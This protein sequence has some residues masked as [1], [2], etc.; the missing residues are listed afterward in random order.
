MTKIVFGAFAHVD[1]G[2]TSLAESLLFKCGNRKQKGR[3][4]H[5]DAF[6]DF[7]NEERKRG[8]TIF[9]K[10]ARLNYKDKE[11]IFVDTP[12]HNELR[13]EAL[14]TLKILDA[15][16]LL[17]NANDNNY[18]SSK[19]FL[20][21]LLKRNI[22]IIIFINKMDISYFDEDAILQR[23]QNQLDKRCCSL[24]S[25]YEN[26]ALE[27]EETMSRYLNEGYIDTEAVQK[28]FLSH[29]YLPVIF[30]SALKD[31]NTLLL[32]DIIA[33]YVKP[34]ETAN[35][36]NLYIYKIVKERNEKLA[37]ARILSGT[38]ANKYTFKDNCQVNEIL[39]YDGANYQ[40][41]KEAKQGDIV[42][43]KGL[44]DVKIGTY[45]PANIIDQAG[46]I[47]K[48][49]YRIKADIDAYHLFLT[50]RE[51]NDEMP[52]LNITLNNNS[53]EMYLSG[54]LQQEII[55]SLIKERYNLTISFHKPQIIYKET[56]A[57]EVLGVGHF[58][59]LRHYAEVIVRLSPNNKME[60]CSKLDNSYISNMLNYLTMYPP[61]GILTDSA[62]SNVR[63]EI[64]DLR[65]HLKHTE[66]QDVI[67]AL[68]RAIR[69]ALLKAENVLL[70]PYF[71]V[72]I[73]SQDN[74][75]I[76][77]LNRQQLNFDIEDNQ[78]ITYL[79]VSD[80]NE[81]IQ[82]LSITL[83]DKFVYQ[84]LD[85]QYRPSANQQRVVDTIGYNPL[86]DSEK[87][88][89]SIFCSNGA[90]HYVEPSMVEEYMHLDLSRFLKQ[91]SSANA[92]NPTKIS[93]AELQRVMNMTHRPKERYIP[94][95]DY[96]KPA[97]DVTREIIIENKPLIYLI[98]G[99]NLLH[100]Q[101]QL[102]EIAK[103]DLF[104]ARNKTIEMVADFAGYVNATCILVFDAYLRSNQKATVIEHD[105]I[106]IVYTKE[107]QTADT[108]IELKAK[109]LQDR[110]KVNVVTSDGL[111]QLRVIS[112]GSTRISSREFIQRY[113][114]FQKNLKKQNSLNFN[115][116]LLDLRKLLEED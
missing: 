50:I 70:E 89:G 79:P 42:A 32:L 63:I 97:E 109:E 49:A 16:V 14:R 13:N 54:K 57:N 15:A 4:D 106:T 92:H 21:L 113:N 25:F 114:N 105:N 18:Q 60:Y 64:L 104:S 19:D 108:Y 102:D 99:Y 9:S 82:S 1:A 69:Q 52:D 80:Y 46:D 73:L 41:I 107:K 44:K 17:I 30:G 24:E 71:Q 98:D 27:N 96:K 31:Q 87:P 23:L 37:Y 112:S 2:K 39:C 116:P 86:L 7:S 78:I 28:A 66:G 40:S 11:F 3:I 72:S 93:E 56:I 77:E 100:A 55:T 62:L 53:V 38:L 22:P 33:N 58:E 26:V 61:C 29:E 91:A 34:L 83:K 103:D 90:G 88:A 84:T 10:E 95:N 35:S 20:D 45:L 59:P 51:L 85:I 36:L 94:K 47:N 6:L 81:I 115:R 48:L 110:Y 76:N 101:P 12:G 74:Q 43:L 65:T 111:E 75:I 5:R 8:I 67:E 68:K